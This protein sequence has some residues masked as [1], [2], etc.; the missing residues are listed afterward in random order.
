MTGGLRVIVCGVLL[1]AESLVIT[2]LAALQVAFYVRSASGCEDSSLPR[3]A[4]LDGR[5]TRA[6][7]N[8]LRSFR[9]LLGRVS[10]AAWMIA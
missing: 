8:A 10:G 7:L 2:G 5:R 3:R 9:T 1:W 6:E 4:R